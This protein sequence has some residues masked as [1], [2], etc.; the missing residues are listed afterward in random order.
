MSEPR[1]EI[2]F[3]LL[4]NY[5]S[6]ASAELSNIEQSIRYRYWGDAIEYAEKMK[7]LMDRLIAEF[8]KGL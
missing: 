6:A 7:E 8:Q 3:T 1:Q 5:C 2:N 4:Q